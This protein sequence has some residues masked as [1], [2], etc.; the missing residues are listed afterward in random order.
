MIHITTPTGLYLPGK[1]NNIYSFYGDHAEEYT[2]YP[3]Y[4]YQVELLINGVVK[5]VYKYRPN[6]IQP[7]SINIRYLISP[8]FTIEFENWQQAII[9][10]PDRVLSVRLNVTAYYISVQTG[11]P[12]TVPEDTTQSSGLR[13]YWNGT[14]HDFWQE[15]Y[16]SNT[17]LTYQPTGTT[18]PND[19]PQW[20][21]PRKCMQ[22]PGAYPPG[23]AGGVLPKSVINVAYDIHWDTHRTVTAVLH[24]GIDYFND[25]YYIACFDASGKMTKFGISY[26][27]LPDFTPDKKFVSIPVGIP[28]INNLATDTLTTGMIFFQLTAY[29]AS[30]SSEKRIDDKDCYY[31]VMLLKSNTVFQNQAN[32]T[33]PLTFKIHRGVNNLLKMNCVDILYYSKLGGWWQIPA[34]RRNYKDVSIK[35]TTYTLPDN[36]VITPSYRSESSVHITADDVYTINTNWMTDR[37]ILEVEDMIQSPELYLCVGGINIPVSLVDSSYTVDSTDNRQ[38]KSYTFKFKANYNKQTIR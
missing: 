13:F 5:S 32:S 11:E 7:I 24:D 6:G 29:G 8:Y 27:N 25:E 3:D 36:R 16:N 14:S 2:T 31:Q 15:R 1:D 21:G 18:F 10:Y 12:V 33:V 17:I 9:N 37:E 34:Y 19:R 22:Y 4:Y 38:L 28:E 20:V 26:F 35:T 23:S 30:I